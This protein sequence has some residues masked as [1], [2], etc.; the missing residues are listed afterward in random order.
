MNSLVWKIVA[1]L[2][3]IGALVGYFKYTQDKIAELNKEVATKEFA[4]KAANETIEQQQQAM[5]QQQEIL[6]KTSDEYQAARKSLSD[7]ESKFNR[8]GRDF[9]QIVSEK[10]NE[11][12]RKA[13]AATKRVF[14]CIESTVNRGVADENC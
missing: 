4:L 11:I 1:V 5:A 14:R 7:L 10:P 12:E 8:D 9:S 13:N 2:I 3:V 6:T